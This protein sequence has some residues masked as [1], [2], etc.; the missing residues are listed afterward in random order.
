MALREGRLDELEYGDRHRAAQ[1]AQTVAQVDALL[2]DLPAELGVRSWADHLRI[3]PADRELVNG[4]LTEAKAEGRLSA[5]EC[6]QRLAG[7][8]AATVY[9]DLTRLT[10]GI[11]G[12]PRARRETLLVSTADRQAVLDRLSRLVIEEV[13]GADE[14]AEL[15]A[16]VRGA[17]LYRD[18]DRITADEDKRV[19]PAE[20]AR[21]MRLLDEAHAA[22]RLDAAEHE[23]RVAAAGAARLDADL[24][25]LLTDLAALPAGSLLSLSGQHRLSDAERE[26]ALQELQHAV[27]DGRLTQQEYDDRARAA[28]EITTVKRLRPLLADLVE[29]RPA[30]ADPSDLKDRL[31]G[32]DP[33]DL[34]DRLAAKHRPAGATDQATSPGPGRRGAATRR[35]WFTAVAAV[36]AGAAVIGGIRVAGSDADDGSGTAAGTAPAGTAPA[37]TAR[38]GTAAGRPDPAVRWAAPYDRPSGV[39][40]VGNWVT[41]D[42]VIRARTDRV[43]AYALDSGREAWAFPVPA[44]HAVCTMSRT[45]QQNVG[46]IGYGPDDGSRCSTIVALDT[47]TGKALW[48][49]ERPHPD[50][51]F[52][53]GGGDET[54]LTGD[55][56]LVKDR[57]GFVAVGP[58]DNKQRW[59]APLAKGCRAYSVT[60]AGDAAALVT[61]CPGHAAHLAVVDAATGRER[62]RTRLPTG[63]DDEKSLESAAQKTI[64]VLS[65]DPAVVRTGDRGGSF[66]SFDA[67]GRTRASIAQSQQDLD[68]A[69]A[70]FSGSPTF[71]AR[72]AYPVV[73]VGDVL[74]A[75]AKQVGDQISRHVAGFSLTD[76]RRLWL[77][78]EDEKISYLTDVWAADGKIM[79]T[80]AVMQPT[81]LTVSEA[82]GRIQRTTTAQEDDEAFD[83]SFAHFEVSAREDR[84]VL[85]N[86]DGTEDP[87][88]VVLQ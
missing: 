16:R 4:W 3:R 45:V 36:V 71:A 37:G 50:D 64:V 26:L 6:D 70:D 75:M 21:A 31:A 82:D 78:P 14:H 39:I 30:G 9:A 72:P 63:P 80:S 65:V 1:A 18:L 49:R 52:D 79:A 13:L 54:A 10:A 29:S 5:A 12:P 44:R 19:A 59:R 41:G 35:W 27:D 40:G 58:R 2:A 56:A 76:G 25:P 8:A 17:R 43:V 42:S 88:V 84:Y 87:P 67:R 85:V 47:G 20:R 38:A 77:T 62:W 51:Y 69:G 61:A 83:N 15:Q 24:D 81:F 86:A 7:L 68:L 57:T 11:P 55:V 53:G 60:A 74:A 48:Q 46:L 33:S 34:K 73:V 22:G 23:R 66:L 28:R 32:A